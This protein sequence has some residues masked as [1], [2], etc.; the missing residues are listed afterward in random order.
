MLF[1][2]DNQATVC[3]EILAAVEDANRGAAKAYGADDISA[4]LNPLF[5][6]VLGIIYIIAPN[7]LTPIFG[8]IIL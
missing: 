7:P 8:A 4:R 5:S 2:S 6:E 3:P 1:W